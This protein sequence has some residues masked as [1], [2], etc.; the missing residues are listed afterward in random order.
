MGNII[1]F[2]RPNPRR[3][4][5]P[6]E[7]LA[8]KEEPDER[9]RQSRERSRVATTQK[10]AS[11]AGKRADKR[12]ERKQVIVNLLADGQQWTVARLMRMI[13][14]RTR[15]PIS[16]TT[17]SAL[18]KELEAEGRASNTNQFWSTVSTT[19]LKTMTYRPNLNNDSDDQ[20]EAIAKADSNILEQI[21]MLIHGIN[22][23]EK[24]ALALNAVVAI[25]NSHTQLCVVQ[26]KHG[27]YSKNLAAAIALL[28]HL[29]PSAKAELAVDILSDDWDLGAAED[30]P[31]TP[32]HDL[33]QSD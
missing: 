24:M 10:I 27:Q 32:H 17:V 5:S 25:D 19:N 6:T 12:A 7:I 30:T 15:E 22:W 16:R 3:K 20:I 33:Q 1:Q 4:W 2:P 21:A 26:P 13:E 14:C 18:L 11:D 23:H 29:S 28:R 31:S 8:I 9:I